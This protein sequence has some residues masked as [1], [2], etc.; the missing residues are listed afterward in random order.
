[1]YISA[2]YAAAFLAAAVSIVPGAGAL[3]ALEPNRPIRGISQASERARE[4][5]E[6][7]TVA[8]RKAAIPRD[9]TLEEGPP[10]QHPRSPG[11][12]TCATASS[13]L[14]ASM[15][16][17][18]RSGS[19]ILP[20]LDVEQGASITQW[21]HQTMCAPAPSWTMATIRAKVTTRRRPSIRRFVGK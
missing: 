19:T 7:W 20:P 9:F 21:A 6:Y 18:T 14:V 17:K 10:R 15:E 1:M 13:S 4:V 5:R 11:R 3:A 8:R 2:S 12:F 16:K